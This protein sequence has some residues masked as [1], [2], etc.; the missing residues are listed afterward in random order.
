[1]T[2]FWLSTVIL[3]IA[4]F[5]F[6]ALPLF[7]KQNFDDDAR[8]DELNKAFYKDRLEEL[9][10][11]TDAGVVVDQDDLI[12][13]L[14]QSLLE[15]I[16][17]DEKKIGSFT[18]SPMTVFGSSALL[19]AVISYATYSVFGSLDKVSHWQNINEQLPALTQ[20][21]MS[22]EQDS[23]SEDELKDLKLAL[24]TRL[25]YQPDDAQGWLLLGRIALADRDADTATGAM[26]KAHNL[27]PKDPDVRLGY[28]QS[29]MMSD[30]EAQQQFARS[31]LIGLLQDDYVDLRVYSLLAFNAYQRGNYEESIR[32][33]RTMQKL[34]GPDDSRYSMLNRSIENAE[35]M[36]GKAVTTTSVPITITV[37]Q[38]VQLPEQGVLVVSIHDANGTPIPVAA[39]RYP[40]GTFPR[41]VVLDDANVMMDGQSISQ[42]DSLIVK[43]RI[44][45]DGNVTTKEGDWYGESQAV[46]MGDQVALVIDKQY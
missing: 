41:T 25:H 46:K 16:P 37:D 36:L 2:T 22:P 31:I 33:W 5:A 7:R 35:K 9:E 24:R 44:D 39:A 26:E 45:T 3:T 11:E 15:D 1:M 20:K 28:A 17:A 19:L 32:F 21:L 30:N 23:L 43:A 18:I 42:L 27:D 34:I 13:D 8:R 14:K 4:G 29:L 12:V 10:D 6:I 40:I 38:N